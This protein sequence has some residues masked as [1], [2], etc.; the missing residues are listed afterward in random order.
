MR[1]TVLSI[2]LALAAGAHAEVK[3]TGAFPTD[4]TGKAVNPQLGEPFYLTV[5][6]NVSKVSK[7][8]RV[9]IDSPA[10]VLDCGALGFGV[11][12]PGDYWIRQGA[13]VRMVYLSPY[14]CPVWN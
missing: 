14:E 8:Y 11:N 2:L 13:I 3:I 4:R 12:A 1:R 10:V 5:T 9:K 7:P 6:L